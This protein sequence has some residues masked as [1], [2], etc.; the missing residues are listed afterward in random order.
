MT[1]ALRDRPIRRLQLGAHE[2]EVRVRESPRA[3]TARILIGPLRPL[4]II[5]PAGTPDD[6]VDGF[7]VS[8][9]HWIADKLDAV[10]V[11]QARPARLGLDRHGVVWIGAA[12]VPVAERHAEHTMARG[13]GG[14]LEV[15]GPTGP[16]RAEAICRWYRREARRRIRDLAARESARLALAFRS[17]SVRDQKTRWGSCSRAGNLSFNW[18]LV[19]APADVMT[20]VVVHELCHLAV[21][22]HSKPFWHQL[23]AAYPGWQQAAAWLRENGAELRAYAP[24]GALGQTELVAE[25]AASRRPASAATSRHT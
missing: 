25:A 12:A 19:I 17:V 5:V 20:Y 9:R 2:V 15:C 10:A 6:E 3:R 16:A 22:S 18:R 1:G 7:L 24:E 23:E 14:R 4:E 8:R 21:P 11:E 13:G